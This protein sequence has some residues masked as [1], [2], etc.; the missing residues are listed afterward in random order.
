MKEL[1]AGNPVN[2]AEIIATVLCFEMKHGEDPD[3]AF[4]TLGVALDYVRA[5]MNMSAED[6]SDSLIKVATAM[7]DV[8]AECGP[9]VV[10]RDM[11]SEVM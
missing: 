9:I 3:M 1:H 11:E 8:D 2:D 10:P 7:L 4:A 6:M 5:M